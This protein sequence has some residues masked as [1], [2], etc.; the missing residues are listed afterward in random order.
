MAKTNFV[1]PSCGYEDMEPGMCPDCSMELE[2]IC[3]EC[4]NARSECVCEVSKL[5]EEEK[6][7]EK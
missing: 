2:E 3:P 4:G 6:E 7:K 5:D 1:C